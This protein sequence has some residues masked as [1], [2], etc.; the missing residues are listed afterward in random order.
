MGRLLAIGDIHGCFTAL[1][2]LLETVELR[3]DDTLI[4]LGDYVNKGP[5][6]FAVLDYMIHLQQ[7][8]HLVPLRGNH[9]KMLLDARDDDRG[10][11]L[12]QRVGGH[13]TLD[14]YSPIEGSPGQLSDIPETHWRFL[15]GLRLYH[16]TKSH[17]FVHANAYPEVP[18]DEQ[19]EFML[20]GERSTTRHRTNPPRLWYADTPHRRPASR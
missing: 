18:L 1:K 13:R 14:S 12:F 11:R 2:T 10:L 7:Q 8:V 6:T 15:D 3:H 19:P 20:I 17:F 16:E 4:T 9:E 5:N